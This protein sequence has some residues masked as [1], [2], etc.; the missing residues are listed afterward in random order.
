MI[1]P[2]TKLVEINPIVGHGVV[3]TRRI[4]RGSL[5]WVMDPLDRAIDEAELAAL[6][7]AYAPLIDRWTFSDGRGQRVLCWDH[8]RYVNHS[9]APNCGGTEF[10]FEIAL[11]DIELGEQLSNDYAT[12]NMGPSEGFDCCCGAPRCRGE[13]D[14]LQQPEA[15]A[16]VRRAVELALPRLARVRQPLLPL[17]APE[18]LAA[19]RRALGLAPGRRTRAR[20]AVALV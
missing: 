6:D 3:A 16:A 18:R 13:V 11:R 19:A 4:P 15:I 9:C 10:G 2:H 14:H 12:L 5:T 1:H 17:L 20:E 8:G 7:P